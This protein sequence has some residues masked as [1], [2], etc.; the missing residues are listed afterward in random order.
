MLSVSALALSVS[1]FC[2]LAADPCSRKLQARKEGNADV[3]Y[4]LEKVL[5]VAMEEKQKTLRPEI[6]LLN[7][8]LATEST[9]GRR[10]VR[11]LSRS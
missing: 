1:V 8:L 2:L 4:K 9:E 5:T 10:S 3:K 7:S 6:Q 11:A